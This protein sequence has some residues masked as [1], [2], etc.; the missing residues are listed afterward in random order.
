MAEST[1]IREVFAEFGYEFDTQLLERGAMLFEQLVGVIDRVGQALDKFSGSAEHAQQPVEEVSE[2]VERLDEAAQKTGVSVDALGKR[3]L[4]FA[5]IRSAFDWLSTVANETSRVVTR[6]GLLAEEAAVLRTAARGNAASML[7]WEK[8]LARVGSFEGLRTL[9][10]ELAAIEDPAARAEAAQKAL[11]NSWVKVMPVLERGSRG[12]D[13]MASKTERLGGGF[14]GEGAQ[15]LLAFTNLMGDLATVGESILVRVLDKVTKAF[16]GFA[17]A[18]D[19]ITGP[20]FKVIDESRI[21]EVVLVALTGAVTIFGI[22]AAIAWAA[23]TW[24][25]LALGAAIAAVVVVVEDLIVGIEGGESAIGAFIDSVFG[26]GAATKVFDS[27]RAAWEWLYDA[28]M[29]RVTL[30]KNIFTDLFN[31]WSG[32]PSVIGEL[33]DS[34]LGIGAA[35]SIIGGIKSIFEGIW[36]AMKKVAG[37]AIDVLRP[38]FGSLFDNLGDGIDVVT[39][40]AAINNL[41]ERFA[42]VHASGQTL[43]TSPMQVAERSAKVETE[44]SLTVNVNRTATDRELAE[45]ARRVVQ[46]E[47]ERYS[48]DIADALVEVA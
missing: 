15:G 28:F 29:S 37:F 16:D 14:A 25:L 12:L 11:G 35:E 17:V 39:G 20:I 1:P 33:I 26:A 9:A 22:K 40:T 47:M 13:E 3:L 43:E 7:D 24:P 23:A 21:L 42:R 19:Q 48:R 4:Q 38:I 31:L 44:Q 27:I 2:E 41:N 34:L 8:A 32:G 18:L 5:A 10:D 36:D 45:Q 6:F 30:I 46:G